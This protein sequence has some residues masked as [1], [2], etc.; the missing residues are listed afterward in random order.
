MME[1]AMSRLLKVACFLMLLPTAAPRGADL[2][3]DEVR[4]ALATAR[5]DKPADF[6][7]RSLETLDLSNLDF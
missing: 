5:P 1:E 6:S 4:A 2:S 7:G 3:A